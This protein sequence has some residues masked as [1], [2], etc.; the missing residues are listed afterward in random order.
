MTNIVA[1]DIGGTNARFALA[2][3]AP[4]AAPVLSEPVKLRAADYPTLAAA[5]AE[6][7]ARCPEPLPRAAALAVACPVDG[8]ILKLTNSPWVLRKST[9]KAQLGLDDLVIVN[10]FGAVTRAVPHLAAANLVHLCGPDTGLPAA[11]A[12]S[13]IGPGTGLGVGLLLR[14]EAGDRVVETEGGH[15]DFAP[16]DAIEDMLLQRLRARYG[17]VSVERV[18]AGPGLVD[19]YET[20]AH[21]E[22]AAVTILDDKELWPVAIDGSNPL[23]AAALLRFCAALGCATGNLALAHLA[24]AVVLAGGIPPRILPILKDSGFGARFRAKGRFEGLM[25]A[26]PVYACVHPDPGLMGAAAACSARFA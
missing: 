3:V 6:F 8:D 4:G 16:C 9:L 7:A 1:M 12:I 5:W 10:D 24:K 13:V 22:G 26:I 14:D 21:A 20:L 23:A 11:G 25:A 17:R 19:I 18:C 15:M 2:T